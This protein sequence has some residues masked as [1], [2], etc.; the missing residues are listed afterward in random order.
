[1]AFVRL[2]KELMRDPDI[3]ARFVPII[4]DEARTFGMDSLFPTAKIYSPLGQTYM[5]VD[6]QLMLSYQ[7]SK[8]GQI[9]HEGIT[10]AGSV[11]SFIAAGTSYA[12]HEQPMIPIY[13]FYSMFGF[14]R[15]G[16]MLWGAMDQMTRGFLLGA[17]AGRTTLNGEGLQH[18]HGHS[19]LQASTNPGV[20]SYDPAYAYE[21]GHIVRD[22]LSR[23][24]GESPEDVFYYLTVYNEPIPQPPEPEG[25]DVEG[26]LRGM[27][28]VAPAADQAAP[29]RA[30]LL[31]SGVA[32]PWA[33]HAQQILAA[34]WGVHA[35]VWSVTSWNGLRRDGLKCDRHNLT[36]PDEPRQQAYVTQRLA[37]QPGPV[38][39]VSDW[40]RAVADQVQQWVPQQR[41]ASLGTD[42]WGMSDTRGA[43]RRH[44]L[45]DAQ[46]ITVQ[47]LALLAADG[48]VDPRAVPDAIQRYDLCNPA[49]ADTYTTEGSSE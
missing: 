12:T 31:A 49:A 10:E 15:T 21:L 11:G 23:M 42:G 33:I 28:L 20:R 39:A 29:R 24:Y 6:R 47:T 16:D 37:D 43:L 18:E 14:Q 46:S 45:V 5:S 1:M 3:G 26:I 44:F 48:E 8:Q 2:L 9:L 7:E 35:D 40:M 25:V 30:Q 4:P 22:G 34:E 17:T 38:I 19:L 32:V 13:I 41:Y 27:H 36:R